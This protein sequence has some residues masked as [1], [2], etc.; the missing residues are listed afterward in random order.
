MMHEFTDGEYIPPWMKDQT[1]KNRSRNYVRYK[2]S[3]NLPIDVQL[4]H[5][6][7]LTPEEKFLIENYN[8]MIRNIRTLKMA[9]FQNFYENCPKVGCTL[10]RKKP[11]HGNDFI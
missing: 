4:S 6:D 11:K 5:Y 7:L 2:V 9:F 10:K 8:D 3:R 1:T